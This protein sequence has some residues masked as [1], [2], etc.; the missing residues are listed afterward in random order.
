MRKA[1]TY[2]LCLPAT[3]AGALLALLAW[4]LLGG[5][6]RLHDGCLWLYFGARGARRWRYSTTL[7]HTILLHPAHHADRITQKHELVHVDQFRGDCISALAVAGVAVA[8]GAHWAAALVLLV[9]HHWFAYL[10]HSAGAWMRGGR[11]Y[12]DNPYERH[13][14]WETEGEA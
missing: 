13:A 1:I 10:G 2:A 4:P 11:A 8:G 5:S 7:G 14:R 3:L 12:K 9:L 6:W